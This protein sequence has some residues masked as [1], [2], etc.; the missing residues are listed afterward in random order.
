MTFAP[1]RQN[2]KRG[3]PKAAPEI[4]IPRY[5]YLEHLDL[6]T[7]DPD[8]DNPRA[9][10]TSADVV[11]LRASIE[12]HGLLSPLVVMHDNPGE[13][14]PAR[15]RVLCGHRRLRALL[16][17]GQAHAPAFGVEHETGK[18]LAGVLA[19]VENGQREALDPVLESDRIAALV[20]RPG[21][22]TRDVAAQLG[23]SPDYVEERLALSGL[24]AAWRMARDVAPASKNGE[25]FSVAEWPMRWL[26]EVALLDPTQQDELLKAWTERPWNR[27]RH[28]ETLREEVRQRLGSLGVAPFDLEAEDVAPGCVSCAKCP[29]HSLA[30]PGLFEGMTKAADLKH[31]LCRDSVCYGRKVEAAA[32]ERVRAAKAKHGEKLVVLTNRVERFEDDEDAPTIEGIRAIEHHQVVPAKKGDKGAVPAVRDFGSSSSVQ[33]VRPVGSGHGGGTSAPA[34]KA[35]KKTLADRRNDLEKR[36]ARAAVDEVLEWL[37]DSDP[38]SF[39]TTDTVALELVGAFG[40]FGAVPRRTADLPEFVKGKDSQRLARLN[41]AARETTEGSRERDGRNRWIVEA[42]ITCASRE[43]R[44]TLRLDPRGGVLAAAQETHAL[45]ELLGVAH[46]WTA[47]LEKA[48]AE[49]PEP[50]A[51][52]AQEAEAAAKGKGK[53]AAKGKPAAPSARVKAAKAD[54]DTA[55]PKGK[56]GKRAKGKRAAAADLEADDGEDPRPGPAVPRRYE[57]DR[58]DYLARLD[59]CPAC[60]QSVVWHRLESGADV[61]LDV[62]SRVVAV[63]AAGRTFLLERHA[64]LC[65]PLPPPF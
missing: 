18:A 34:R 36:R 40:A 23:R 57:L 42:V 53:K 3:R 21:W 9:R 44:D 13:A 61:S 20:A 59:A 37:E 43:I 45:C 32:A 47:A 24:S 25:T 41:A 14:A 31:A 65:T 51:W 16:D 12:K 26:R 29:K 39:P 28:L 30:T 8:P 27:P 35:K 6:S 4:H 54:L 7:V 52:A 58:L 33:W 15:W 17:L 2:T 62:Q 19:L 55:K 1:T 22:N 10:V 46:R 5:D 56:A 63:G 60:G 50:K 48:I 38:A 49:R 11:E 64:D